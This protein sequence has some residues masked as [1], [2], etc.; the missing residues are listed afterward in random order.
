MN[1]SSSDDM[2]ENE[3]D[4]QIE[5]IKENITASTKTSV[6]SSNKSNSIPV[7][8]SVFSFDPN[9]S[10]DSFIAQHLNLQVI[11]FNLRILILNDIIFI[12]QNEAKQA[13]AKVQSD[14]RREIELEKTIVKNRS[15]LADIVNTMF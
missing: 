4:Q 2:V 10:C 7:S 12:K 6:T 5:E 13:L 11:Y 9:D 15:P 3:T 14:V 1:E 8:F